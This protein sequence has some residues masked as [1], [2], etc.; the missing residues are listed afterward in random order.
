MGFGEAASAL[1]WRSSV[2]VREAEL[3]VTEIQGVL[4]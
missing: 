4:I 2:V 3:S 1:C